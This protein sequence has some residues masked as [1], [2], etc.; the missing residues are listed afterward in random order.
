MLLFSAPIIKQIKFRKSWYEVKRI[1]I[2]LKLLIWSIRYFNFNLKFSIETLGFT[3]LGSTIS[4]YLFVEELN[5]FKTNCLKLGRGCTTKKKMC[6]KPIKNSSTYLWKFIKINK[7]AIECHHNSMLVSLRSASYSFY[8][9]MQTF[10]FQHFQADLLSPTST[11]VPKG[12]LHVRVYE[13]KKTITFS[14][15]SISSPQESITKNIKIW[16]HSNILTPSWYIH[17]SIKIPN[18]FKFAIP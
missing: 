3:I 18:F 14:T 10:N 5:Q 9:R 1:F 16:K 8:C 17:P 13:V 4:L 11:A 6:S 2:F 12:N 7:S 15:I